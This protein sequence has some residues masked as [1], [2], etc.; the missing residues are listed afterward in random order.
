[1]GVEIRRYVGNQI[2]KLSS[3]Y[4][5]NSHDHGFDYAQNSHDHGIDY[6][7]LRHD[8]YGFISKNDFR[9]MKNKMRRLQDSL[10]SLKQ[11]SQKTNVSKVKDG[12]SDQ[13]LAN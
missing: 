9:D 4:A 6:A 2:E 1:M 5:E 10:T 12:N 13:V 8:H 11:D 7:E 3:K